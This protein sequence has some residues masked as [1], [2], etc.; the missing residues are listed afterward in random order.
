MSFTLPEL[1]YPKEALEP[2]LSRETL[3]YHYGK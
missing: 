1:P 2:H 3:E